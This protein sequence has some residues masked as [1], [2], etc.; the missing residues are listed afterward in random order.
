MKFLFTIT[1]TLLSISLVWTSDEAVRYNNEII[2]EQNKIGEAILE[3]SNNPND[4]TL[5]NIKNKGEES[6]LVLSKIKGFETDKKFIKAAKN[7]FKFYINISQKEYKEM[8]T[9]LTSGNNF[10]KEAINKKIKE[11]SGSISKK[12]KPLDEKF[13]AAQKEFAKKYNFELSKNELQERMKNT[14]ND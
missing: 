13:Q 9:L 14:N 6:L 10:T 3:F 4:F 7:L 11:L 8:L 1:I 5:L 12:E 2:T